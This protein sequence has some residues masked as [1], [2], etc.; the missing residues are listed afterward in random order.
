MRSAHWCLHLW[1]INI[2]VGNC[3]DCCGVYM[4]SN[5]CAR[6][7]E[8]PECMYSITPEIVMGNIEKYLMSVL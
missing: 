4:D 7:L 8:K 1:H 6:G 5:R 3:H 2:K